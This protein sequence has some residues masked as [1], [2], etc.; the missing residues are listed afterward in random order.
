[1]SNKI[2]VNPK[3]YYYYLDMFMTDGKLNQLLREIVLSSFSEDEIDAIWR[4]FYECV[5][6]PNGHWKN[7]HFWFISIDSRRDEEKRIGKVE[8]KNQ[9][10]WEDLYNDSLYNF[11]AERK[12][13]CFDVNLLIIFFFA[14]ADEKLRYIT[15]QI[16]LKYGIINESDDSETRKKKMSNLISK[17]SNINNDYNK[18]EGEYKTDDEYGTLNASIMEL[19]NDMHSNFAGID[20]SE[21]F[22]RFVSTIK[23]TFDFCQYAGSEKLRDLYYALE[24]QLNEYKERVSVNKPINIRDFCQKNNCEENVVKALSSK[25]KDLVYDENKEYIYETTEED[26]VLKVAKALKLEEKSE[27]FKK[28]EEEAEIAEKQ[29]EK[30]SLELEKAKAETKKARERKKQKKINN[31]REKIETAKDTTKSAIKTTATIILVIV[32]L[33]SSISILSSISRKIVEHK[34]IDMEYC[35]NHLVFTDDSY[36]GHGEVVGDAISYFRYDD[37]ASK[38][39]IDAEQLKG[40]F[41]C[42]YKGSVSDLKNGDEVVIIADWNARKI[43]KELGFKIKQ[44]PPYKHKVK[45]SGLLDE[46]RVNIFDYVD[47]NLVGYEGVCRPELRI[48]NNSV[49][50][51]RYTL[52]PNADRYSDNNVYSQIKPVSFQVFEG[53]SLVEDVVVYLDTEGWKEVEYPPFRGTW[54]QIRLGDTI[55]LKVE[56]CK[57]DVSLWA[58]RVPVE[59]VTP[60]ISESNITIDNL[61]TLITMDSAYLLNP[62]IDM[63]SKLS[64]DVASKENLSLSFKAAYIVSKQTVEDDFETKLIVAYKNNY[65]EDDYIFATVYNPYLTDDGKI[66]MVYDVPQTSRVYVEQ[67]NLKKYMSQKF[68]GIDYTKIL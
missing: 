8:A 49:N 40:Y 13:K 58:D 43:K 22:S 5:T 65:G 19:R 12:L 18:V 2:P 11:S 42:E 3:I 9:S 45:V 26:L 29:F 48:G 7:K 64:K 32:L 57:D 56:Q 24:A 35:F 36:N 31:A 21:S 44:S 61:G 62:T 14:V 16:C 67:N 30:A 15:E 50:V 27:E 17:L 38:K 37:I 55:K 6:D 34:K 59:T 20:D 51:G 23:S 60:M 25:E 39:K 10:S 68:V 28:A 66:G 47:V 53:G 63:F 1:M 33:I 54:Y 46:P 41:T 4:K 52:R